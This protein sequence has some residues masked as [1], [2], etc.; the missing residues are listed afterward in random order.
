MHTKNDELWNAANTFSAKLICKR[1]I[2]HMKNEAYS[3]IKKKTY[4][5]NVKKKRLAERN[6]GNLLDSQCYT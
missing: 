5:I 3:F 6:T 1:Q 2:F 4:L